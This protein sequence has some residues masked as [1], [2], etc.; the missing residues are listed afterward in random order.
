M[1]IKKLPAVFCLWF[2]A[3]AVMA[4]PVSSPTNLYTGDIWAL[5]DAKKVMAAASDITLEKYPDCDEATVDKRLVRIYNAD[6]T[7]QCQDEAFTKVLTE[8]GK[9]NNRTLSLSFM[10]PY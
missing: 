2:V 4:A 3:A 6:G 8:K 7:G 9:R 5:L 10:L 1:R